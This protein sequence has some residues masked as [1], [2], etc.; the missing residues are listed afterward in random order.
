MWAG[1]RTQDLVHFV[2]LEKSFIYFILDML[3]QFNTDPKNRSGPSLG[4]IWARVS[5]KQLLGLGQH[6]EE[7]VTRAKEHDVMKSSYL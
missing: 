1:V 5:L 2:S 7:S 6:K 4:H 3:P